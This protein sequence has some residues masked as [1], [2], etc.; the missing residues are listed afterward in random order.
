MYN[1]SRNISVQIDKNKKSHTG[2]ADIV[3]VNYVKLPLQRSAYKNQQVG[4]TNKNTGKR[5]ITLSAKTNFQ[6]RKISGSVKW[7][8]SHHGETK[9]SCMSSE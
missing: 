9:M 6:T 8:T 7:L 2:S 1:V 3:T 4:K 5:F